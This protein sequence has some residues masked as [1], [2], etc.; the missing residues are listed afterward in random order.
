MKCQAQPVA[1]ILEQFDGQV[2]ELNA[3]AHGADQQFAG[4]GQLAVAVTQLFD[5]VEQLLVI[6]RT[7]QTL[8]ELQPLVGVGDVF[9][10]EEGRQAEADFR[11]DLLFKFLAA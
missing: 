3:Q 10:G 4:M 5:Q 2:F 8:V 9:F 6:F 1:V 7:G 11:I